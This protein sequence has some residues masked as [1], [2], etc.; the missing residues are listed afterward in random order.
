VEL[1]PHIS[2][3][4]GKNGQGKTSLLEATYLLGHH[5]SFRTSRVSEVRSYQ[6]DSG[7]TE[8]SGIF[9][10]ESGERSLSYRFEGGKR[11]VFVNNN[12]VKAAADFFGQVKII[13]FTPQDLFIV[14]G[15]PSERR[16]YIDK[17]LSISD[18]EYFLSLLRYTKALKNRNAMLLGGGSIADLKPW[19]AILCT[20]ARLISEKRI[21]LVEKLNHLAGSIY[22]SIEPEERISLE[23]LG[24]TELMFDYERDLRLKSTTSG[25]HRD[26][27]QL[28]LDTGFGRKWA[29]ETASQGQI[30]SLTLALKLASVE[31][32]RELGQTPIV[33]LDDVE[34]ELDENRRSKLLRYLTALGGQILI[35][36]TN[37]YALPGI[38]KEAIYYSVESGIINPVTL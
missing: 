18:R 6:T 4:V 16:A 12:R 13:E 17:L 2:V 36:T 33:L 8:V 28:Y 35:A 10:D 7:F 22:Q 3:F 31:F 23:Y 24:E 9:F 29:K 11:L 30:R 26:D 32:L 25:V 38:E 20:E 14:T 27:L 34:S 1:S 21:A 5:R 19:E 15:S 37:R